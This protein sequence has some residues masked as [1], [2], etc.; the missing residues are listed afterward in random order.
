MFAIF[1]FVRKIVSMIVSIL[2]LSLV[3]QLLLRQ[4]NE[5]LFSLF[6]NIYARAFHTD[7]YSFLQIGSRCSSCY[8]TQFIELHYARLCSHRHQYINSTFLVVELPSP[9]WL[10]LLLLNCAYNSVVS[11]NYFQDVCSL[12]LARMHFD[13]C[14]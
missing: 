13:M 6:T 8:R 12:M 7:F 1:L 3:L 4:I 14:G 9:M 2:L 10:P 5:C 11:C